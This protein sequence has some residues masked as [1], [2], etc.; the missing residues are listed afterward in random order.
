MNLLR[1]T[2]LSLPFTECSSPPGSVRWFSSVIPLDP[3]STSLGVNHHPCYIKEEVRQK[4]NDSLRVA[5]FRNLARPRMLAEFWAW[6][7]PTTS[8]SFLWEEGLLLSLRW[9]L[10]TIVTSRDYRISELLSQVWVTPAGCVLPESSFNYL[11][12]D[13]S[14]CFFTYVGENWE[15]ELGRKQIYRVQF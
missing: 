10:V 4:L 2:C 9:R 5:P 14:C 7:F 12:G 3:H 11:R 13:P 1:P 15:G 8:C 6:V